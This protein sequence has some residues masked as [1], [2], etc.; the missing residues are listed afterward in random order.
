VAS[1]ATF[2]PRLAAI[3]RAQ[4]D[5]PGKMGDRVRVTAWPGYY[6]PLLSSLIS[7][8]HDTVSHCV[9]LVHVCPCA[10][11]TGSSDG[12]ENRQDCLGVFCCL[13]G[14]GLALAADPVDRG[15]RPGSP[16]WRLWVL[17]ALL[18]IAWS[19]R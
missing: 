19:A 3:G 7:L 4:V 2:C 13:F 9:R 6:Q 14:G 1:P 11:Q 10:E 5:E 8:A 15:R 12:W 16:S 17:P 18:M